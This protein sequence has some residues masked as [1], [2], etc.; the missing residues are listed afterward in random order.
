MTRT[1]PLGT[2]LPQETLEV[3]TLQQLQDQIVRPLFEA[4]ADELD[5]IWM[6]EL[7]VVKVRKACHYTLDNGGEF[8]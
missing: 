2:G 1:Y 8:K 3:T 6:V 7:A 5:N 4:D